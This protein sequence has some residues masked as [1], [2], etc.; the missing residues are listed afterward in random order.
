MTRASIDLGAGAESEPFTAP[1]PLA[2]CWTL[3]ILMSAG[4]W[5]VVWRMAAFFI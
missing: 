2:V 5:A 3:W 1:L 4:L